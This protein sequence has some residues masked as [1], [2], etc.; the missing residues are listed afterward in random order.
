MSLRTVLACLSLF[1]V[2]A[3]GQ[4]NKSVAPYCSPTGRGTCNL[5]YEAPNDLLT[6][7]SAAWAYD[8]S[9]R[10]IGNNTEISPGNQGIPVP[11]LPNTLSID[12]GMGGGFGVPEQPYIVGF[13][14]A[15]VF[16]NFDNCW[17]Y[18]ARD[19][20]YSRACQCAFDC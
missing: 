15:G 9:C 5:G 19:A 2:S 1:V 12:V 17:W 4:F 13:Y 7:N 16:H 10:E 11:S 8:N 20:G 6:G 18:D 3:R 14:Y